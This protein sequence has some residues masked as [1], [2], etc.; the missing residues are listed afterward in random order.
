MSFVSFLWLVPETGIWSICLSFLWIKKI[1]KP[2]LEIYTTTWFQAY[3]SSPEI[4]SVFFFFLKED[5]DVYT[6]ERKKT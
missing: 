1:W 2:F 6:L 4:S 5:S 3:D